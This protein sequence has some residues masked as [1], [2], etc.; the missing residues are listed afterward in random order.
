MVKS[1]MHALHT[2]GLKFKSS[3]YIAPEH[4]EDS[5]GDLSGPRLVNQKVPN[6]ADAQQLCILYL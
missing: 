4:C 1:N 2:S 6:T 3:H 5:P